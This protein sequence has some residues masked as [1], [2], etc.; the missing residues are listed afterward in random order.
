MP[1]VTVV[2]T[3]PQQIV[4]SPD[5]IHVPYGPTQSVTWNLEGEGATFADNGI[6]FKSGS[7]GTLTRVSDTQYSLAD[8]NTN[9]SGQDVDYSY[10]INVSY[11]GTTYNVDPEVDNDPEGAAMKV[12]YKSS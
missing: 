4:P 12:R 6:Y 5:P 1:T 9:T 8:D 10:G 3:P 2:F 11:N 7:P